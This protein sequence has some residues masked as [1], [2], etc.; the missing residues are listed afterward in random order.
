[1]WHLDVRLRTLKGYGN[2]N[3]KLVSFVA[4][5]L[6][7]G[8]MFITYKT[9]KYFREIKLSFLGESPFARSWLSFYYAMEKSIFEFFSF[10]YADYKSRRRHFI[11]AFNS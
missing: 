3:N 8:G 2:D 5:P 6:E 10:L 1:M 9:L 4:D 11:M 7:R